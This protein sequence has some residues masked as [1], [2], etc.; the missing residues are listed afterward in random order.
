LARYVWGVFCCAFGLPKSPAKFE[1]IGRWVWDFPV[2]ARTR[3]AAGVAALIWTLWKARNSAVFDKFIPVDPCSIVC[4]ISY[5]TQQLGRS[6][7]ERIWR[8]SELTWWR[9]QRPNGGPW[10]RFGLKT[11]WS[12]AS[13]SRQNVGDATS[14]PPRDHGQRA[15]AGHWRLLVGGVTLPVRHAAGRRADE[16]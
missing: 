5:W 16:V 2:R 3:V 6:G 13:P 12:G 11:R 14:A 8:A 15:A 10:R 1:D 9:S 7:S 4:R